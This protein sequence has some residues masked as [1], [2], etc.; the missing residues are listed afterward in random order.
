MCGRKGGGSSARLVGTAARPV[1]DSSRHRTR[2][3]DV[4]L[5]GGT[6]GNQPKER[7]T[8]NNEQMDGINQETAV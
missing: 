1:A 8:K 3:I 2:T 7:T 6:T 5:V 4:E